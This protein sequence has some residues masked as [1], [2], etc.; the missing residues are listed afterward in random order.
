MLE[1]SETFEKFCNCLWIICL[2]GPLWGS[3]FPRANNYLLICSLIAESRVPLIFYVVI[4][5]LRCINLFKS[6]FL[7]KKLS[8]HLALALNPL[9]CPIIIPAL[10]ISY[11][12]IDCPYLNCL[13]TQSLISS[14]YPILGALW[15]PLRFFF[16]S[17]KFYSSNSDVFILFILYFNCY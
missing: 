2:V 9:L 14:S 1:F 7:L 11:L 10:L 13:M 15:A 5:L 3:L 4:Y 6:W 12:K 17:N 8:T 16:P